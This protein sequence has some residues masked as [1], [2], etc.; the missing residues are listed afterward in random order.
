MPDG[1]LGRHVNRSFYFFYLHQEVVQLLLLRQQQAVCRPHL[2]QSGHI[3]FFRSSGQVEQLVESLSS[4]WLSAAL[5]QVLPDN[6]L[7]TS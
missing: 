7:M 5:I 1:N 6:V 2:F 3:A 4:T